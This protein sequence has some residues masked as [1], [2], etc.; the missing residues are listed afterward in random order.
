MWT[1]RLGLPVARGLD[2]GRF[3]EFCG[4]GLGDGIEEDA[5][6]GDGGAEEFSGSDVLAEKEDGGEEDDD[7]LEG[8]T[9]GGG[10]GGEE[11]ED[12]EAHLVVA[13]VEHAAEDEL[14]GEAER[15]VHGS[16]RLEGG[17][18]LAEHRGEEEGGGGAAGEDAVVVG[19]VEVVLSL[20][21]LGHELLGEELGDGEGDGRDE[22]GGRGE[23]TQVGEV[24]RGARL[25]RGEGDAADDGEEADVDP[26]RRDGAGE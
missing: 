8:V 21:L 23:R 10:D 17:P 9:D 25:A 1:K 5:E 13:V 18:A 2:L 22:R 24:H 20:H 26:P 7:A 11:V 3:G 6:H 15:V 4:P 19:G 16:E 14:A 12:A